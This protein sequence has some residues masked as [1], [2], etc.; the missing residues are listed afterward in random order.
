MGK[1]VRSA[2]GEVVDFD[3]MK[4]KEQIAAAPT[5]LEVKARQNFIENRLKRRI[6]KAQ[7]AV[8]IKKEDVVAP[9]LPEPPAAVDESHIEEDT[10]EEVSEALA[11]VEAM[12]EEPVKE[13]APK[14]VVKK[15]TTK[16]RARP[17]K[18]TEVK[19]EPET[20]EDIIE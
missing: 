5:P 17:K 13:E 1:K 6:K 16:Q 10:K 18:K 19:P 8:D 4:V 15:R 12:S 3:L 11:A 14:K 7:N 2:R 9:E 20:E